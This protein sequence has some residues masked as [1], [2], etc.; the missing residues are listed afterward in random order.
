[1]VLWSSGTLVQTTGRL[2]GPGLDVLCRWDQTAIP[3]S[4]DCI[5]DGLQIT[6]AFFI[7]TKLGASIPAAGFMRDRCQRPWRFTDRR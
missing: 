5:G 2:N 1:M 7:W 3:Y 4:R 6:C